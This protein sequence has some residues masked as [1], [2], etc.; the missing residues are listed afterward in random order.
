[1]SLVDKHLYNYEIPATGYFKKY[2][3][4][5]IFDICY[6]VGKKL[7]D[8]LLCLGR[9]K[10]AQAELFKEYC[11]ALDWIIDTKY[12]KVKLNELKRHAIT[13]EFCNKISYKT[14]KE[15]YAKKL[16]SK[17]RTWLI[18]K[19]YFGLYK[20]LLRIRKQGV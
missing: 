18:Y 3:R 5:N 4:E 9:E 20:K 8:I 6:I 13:L 15:L 16:T 10:W 1:M 12:D 2:Y 19:K 17:F 14:Y 7:N 11:L